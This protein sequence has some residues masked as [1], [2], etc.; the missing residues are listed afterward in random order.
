MGEC[1]I[2]MKRSSPSPTCSCRPLSVPSR[3]P[4]LSQ[5][6][7]ISTG[8]GYGY[9]KD[10]PG[11]TTSSRAVQELALLIV[12]TK[13]KSCIFLSFHPSIMCRGQGLIPM[14]PVQSIHVGP[15]CGNIS[16]DWRC[17]LDCSAFYYHGKTS[18]TGYV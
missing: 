1:V 3:S 5:V 10:K 7:K 4:V 15:V 18:E 8:R 17:L 12:P 6:G 2:L 13:R 11:H 9:G 14:C 16:M